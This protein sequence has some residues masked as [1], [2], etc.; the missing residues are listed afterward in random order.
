[1]EIGGAPHDNMLIT[2]RCSSYDC[3]GF[4]RLISHLGPP[5]SVACIAQH[6]EMQRAGLAITRCLSRIVLAVDVIT[7]CNEY[8]AEFSIRTTCARR[9]NGKRQIA[10]LGWS[11]R[12]GYQ[13]YQTRGSNLATSAVR[14]GKAARTNQQ[15]D[16]VANLRIQAAGTGAVATRCCGD[17]VC[18]F[19]RS[20]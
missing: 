11:S 4:G 20:D 12:P 15:Q 1:M 8:E 18:P 2:K 5:L 7:P 9:K 14:S 10:T 13:V 16:S 3:S 6:I 17:R 19:S